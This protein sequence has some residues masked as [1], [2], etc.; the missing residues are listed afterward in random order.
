MVDGHRSRGIFGPVAA[1][2]QKSPTAFAASFSALSEVYMILLR[3]R[4]IK[5]LFQGSGVVVEP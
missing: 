2:E 4:T 5:M 1:C 3:S